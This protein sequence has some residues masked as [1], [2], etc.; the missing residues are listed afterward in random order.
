MNVCSFCLLNMLYWCV[1]RKTES[2]DVLD[3]VGS[4]IVVSTRGGEVMRIMP[5]LNEDVNEEWISDKTRWALKLLKYDIFF[6]FIYTH[7]YFVHWS[8][9]WLTLSK[10]FIWWTEEA[11]PDPA[12][13]EG[14][15]WTAGSHDLGGCS[16]T[17]GWSSE[18]LHINQNQPAL[19]FED[20]RFQWLGFVFSA[21]GSSGFW[22]RSY[23]RW[24]GRCWGT[25]G[26]EGPTEQTGQWH[27]LHWGDLPSGRCRVSTHM[28][29]LIFL[30]T[31]MRMMSVLISVI[32]YLYI[33]MFGVP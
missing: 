19:S 27:P 5:R 22:G 24:D 32:T 8:C 4:N 11:T 31:E 33:V 21:P 17:R 20:N 16:Y 6:L 30:E 12:N 7:S 23:F 1:H 26:S 28:I 18:W 29:R 15:Q 14:C 25:G 3:A 13:G 10:V 9:F 2:I